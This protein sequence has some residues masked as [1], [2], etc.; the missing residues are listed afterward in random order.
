MIG[1][2]MQIGGRNG[3]HSPFRF[4][5]KGIGFVV[6]RRTKKREKYL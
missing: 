2:Q 6:A 3:T 4:G 5:S 1:S